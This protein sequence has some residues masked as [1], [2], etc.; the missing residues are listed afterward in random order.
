MQFSDDSGE[1]SKCFDQDRLSGSAGFGAAA[2]MI[3]LVTFASML[4]RSN[5]GTHTSGVAISF[6]RT[7]SI[8]IPRTYAKTEVKAESEAE[9]Q[10][11]LEYSSKPYWGAITKGPSLSYETPPMGL[12]E[13]VSWVETVATTQPYRYGKGRLW[14]V[15]TDRAED[16]F[17]IAVA[18]YGKNNFFSEEAELPGY[19]DHFHVNGRTFMNRYSHFRIWCGEML[20]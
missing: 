4:I 3:G 5:Q 2:A 7:R 15:Y 19:F 20:K 18:I 17:K 6:G 11:A 12:M 16:A 9:T 10:I 13:T 8:S 1:R 14:G